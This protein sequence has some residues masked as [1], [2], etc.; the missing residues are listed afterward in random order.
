MLPMR[1]APGRGVEMASREFDPT[2]PLPH[3][4]KTWLRAAR[5]AREFWHLASI[6]ELISA[7]LRMVSA[8]TALAIEE[9]MRSPV[10]ADAA[11][12]SPSLARRQ[13]RRLA[14]LTWN[15]G[16]RADRFRD[17]KPPMDE[18][19]AFRSRLVGCVVGWSRKRKLRKAKNPK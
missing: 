5:V 14:D 3:E 16:S 18:L 7:G 6:D 8:A 9:A 13:T 11:K 1:Y 17:E 19:G 10:L 2:L 4:T 12:Q 15:M